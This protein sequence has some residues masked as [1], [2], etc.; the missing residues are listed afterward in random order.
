M[1]LHK[2]G[3]MSLFIFIQSAAIQNSFNNIYDLLTIDEMQKTTRLNTEDLNRIF[4]FIKRQQNIHLHS[5][6]LSYS[7]LPDL[8]NKMK[9]KKGCEIGT[10][11][12]THSEFILQNTNVDTL[13][14]VDPYRHFSKGEFN[15]PMNLNQDYFDVLYEMVK[16]RLATFLHRSI[17]IRATSMEA[18]TKIKNNEL[19]F[20]YIDGN[21]SYKSVKEDLETWY[22]KVR[23]GGLISGDDYGHPEFPGVKQAVDEFFKNKNLELH[24]STIVKE[25]YWA[26]KF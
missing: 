3:I 15:D 2:I 6:S 17:L 14:S 23:P 18:Y 8:I 9:F 22:E 13:Y 26:I 25:F 16:K 10:A 11:F 4:E 20:V 5:W 1:K 21:H 12:G 7:L 19:D 24:R